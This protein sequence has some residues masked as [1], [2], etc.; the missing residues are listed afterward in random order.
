MKVNLQNL[1]RGALKMKRI[2]AT[3][4]TFVMLFAVCVPSFATGTVKINPYSPPPDVNGLQR[5]EHYVHTK[6]ESASYTVIIPAT[7]V[8][9][10]EAPSKS[11]QYSVSNVQLC[12]G[13]RLKVTLAS[14]GDE[15]VLRDGN[16]YALPYTF[17]TID[18]ESVN[19]D[20]LGY[21]T[22]SEVA[23]EKVTL[24]FNISIAAKDWKTVPVNVYTGNLTFT[25]G[26]I[27]A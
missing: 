18:N 16:G 6:N 2:L 25:V 24:P 3:A 1:K 23:M 8:I 14:Q 13:Q 17:K 11:F 15:K 26:V 19:D 20:E 10:W 27:D 4:L 5:C 22:S 12:A 7:I 9:P 21:I